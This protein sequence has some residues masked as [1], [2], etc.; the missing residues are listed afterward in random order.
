MYFS[1]PFLLG[2]KMFLWEFMVFICS[3]TEA[4]AVE[5]NIW[6]SSEAVFFSKLYV[7]SNNDFCLVKD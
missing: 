1:S 5:K 2:L 6:P 3:E 4:V 7:I